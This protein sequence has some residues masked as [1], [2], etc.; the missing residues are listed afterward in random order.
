MKFSTPPKPLAPNWLITLLIF[1]SFTFPGKYPAGSE[2]AS[3]FFKGRA[4]P[5][6]V[7]RVR[8]VS[9]MISIVDLGHDV[10]SSPAPPTSMPRISPEFARFIGQVADGQAKV[11]RGVYVAGSLA[12]HVVQQPAKDWTYVSEELGNATEFQNA[13]DNGVIGL[14]AHNYLS[15]RLFYNLKSGDQ[16]GVVYGDGS[17]KYYRISGSFQYQKLEPD[18]LSSKLVDLTT[19]ITV[20]S[21]QVFGKFYSGGDHVTLQTCLE[22]NGISTW[23]LYFVVAQPVNPGY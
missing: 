15:G 17:V 9:Q 16:I 20:T 10:I 6:P 1:I 21:G 23:G 18:D 7:T 22:R 8:Q 14:L 3:A 2:K 4:A 13:A 11:V 12:L 19:G 5:I